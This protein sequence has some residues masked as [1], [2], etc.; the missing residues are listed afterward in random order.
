MSLPTDPD[1]LWSQLRP[2]P[3]GLVA[4][5]VQHAATGEVLMLGYMNAEALR[6]TLAVRRVTFYSRSRQRLWEKGESSGNALVLRGLAVDCDG[7]ALLVRADPQGPTCHT[8]APSCFF[9]E[10]R[11]EEKASAAPAPLTV[12]A[13]VFAEICERKAGRGMTNAEGKSYVRTLLAGGAPAIAAKV[14]EEA[15]ELADALAADDRGH[16]AREAADL[17]FHAFV[18]L[19]ARDLDLADVAAVLQRRRGRSGLDE[20][21]ARAT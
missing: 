17:L 4:A 20:K 21:A 12:F 8:G 6:L 9:R 14:R 10:V 5:V 3:D 1:A 19:A 11:D 13:E 18:G 16:I 2:G 15:A 7:D